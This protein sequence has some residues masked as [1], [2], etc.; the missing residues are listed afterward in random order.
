MHVRV[1]AAEGWPK[2]A[3]L[4]L[5]CNPEITPAAEGPSDE[6]CAFKFVNYINEHILA[7]SFL[8]INTYKHNHQEIE[9]AFVIHYKF[10][11]KKKQ[12]NCIHGWYCNFFLHNLLTCQVSFFLISGA[13]LSIKFRF[14]PSCS[15]KRNLS[16]AISSHKNGAR[17]KNSSLRNK[18]SSGTCPP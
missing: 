7:V 11:F 18:N 9:K 15:N 10:F 17:L 4:W 5:K 16:Y 8:L 2:E 6:I 1:P 12:K 13:I 3:D 14:F